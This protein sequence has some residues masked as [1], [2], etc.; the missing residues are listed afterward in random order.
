MNSVD[1]Y[2][3]DP[4]DGSPESDSLNR[5][6]FAAS[7]LN[8]LDR[9]HEQGHSSSVVGLI[10]DWGSGKSS[11][12]AMIK[13]RILKT[14]AHW[15]VTEFNPWAYTNEAAI[16]YGFFRE[17]GSAIPGKLR[18][19]R[20]RRALG[21][22][23]EAISPLGALTS[24]LGFDGTSAI[25][26]V[27][28]L[29]AGVS[30]SKIMRNVER[31]LRKLKHRPILVLIDDMDRLDTSELLLV[32]KLIRL[33]GRLPNVFYLLAYDEL[34]FLDLLEPTPGIPTRQ[35]AQ[36]FLE[37]VV[38]VRVD[39]P[40]LTENQVSRI[41]TALLQSTAEICRVELGNPDIS[42]IQSAYRETLASKFT[43]PRA[44]RRF[45]I[46]VI[47]LFPA[48]HGEVD[49]VD[50]YH[51]TWIRTFYPEL[52]SKLHKI[53]NELT[54]PIP[55]MHGSRQDYS[56][57]K[58]YWRNR[59]SMFGVD[60]E[61]LNTVLDLLGGLFLPI[62]SSL[63][64]TN[65]GESFKEIGM[66]TGIGSR[67]YFDRYFVFGV[68]DDD[69][70][71][72]IVQMAVEDFEAKKES[73]HL[74]E[75]RRHL[76]VNARSATQK[77]EM[78]LDVKPNWPLLILDLL[79][80]EYG[81]NEE[82]PTSYFG[83]APMMEALGRKIALTLSVE[84]I[85][86]FLTDR[87]VEVQDIEFL[88]SIIGSVTSGRDLPDSWR[89][90]EF[91]ATLELLSRKILLI[92]EARTKRYSPNFDEESSKLFWIWYGIHPEKTVAWFRSKIGTWGL[93][94]SLMRLVPQGYGNSGDGAIAVLFPLELST[95]EEFV[96]VERALREL[97]TLVETG[98][99]LDLSDHPIANDMHRQELVLKALR[100][101]E[102]NN[103][104][105]HK[106]D[107]KPE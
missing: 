28:K 90:E 72:A 67:D 33:I 83:T 43:T 5:Y 97:S 96:G 82:H 9:L 6:D 44:L 11:L 105:V 34:T 69:L 1:T 80:F 78:L 93:L 24:P 17:L 89:T 36:D 18:Y 23:G 66:R 49:F 62:R 45:H 106:V 14:S 38:Q 39:M 98:Q 74:M 15:S 19:W 29:V 55:Q 7:V 30:E 92:L 99:P 48:L 95:I 51:I 58:D 70:S 31:K 86:T 21:K 26:G 8:I 52:Y 87:C 76:Q 27:S 2:S 22:L 25:L 85:N 60:D 94:A 73:I 41:A 42:R 12:L 54:E 75:L 59:I 103:Y 56:Q 40:K 4:T 91:S 46:Q 13:N 77:L 10:G 79:R 88:G 71:N 57:A 3:D 16:T 81:V 35:R 100:D 47:A 20:A 53:K 63:R 50:F 101:P 104:Q 65:F 37:K 64:G 68:P 102:V 107:E 32:F 84:E 61:D